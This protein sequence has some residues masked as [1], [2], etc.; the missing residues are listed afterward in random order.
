[1]LGPLLFAA[2]LAVF[3][4]TGY[5]EPQAMNA[6]FALNSASFL[7]VVYTLSLLHVKHIPTVHTKRMRES[8][9][10]VE[11]RAP[12]RQP[13][14]PYR[15]RGDDDVP[16]LAIL[17]LRPHSRGA[18]ST[19]TSHLQPADGVFRRRIDRGRWSWR[20]WGN[21]SDGLTALPMQAIT[22]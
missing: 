20:G 22:P 5:S 21:S 19:P 14:A 2:T 16:G 1:V 11:L 8:S 9:R 3:T 7:I 17:T 15:P 4:K 12:S 18:C 6:A 10:A 13:V